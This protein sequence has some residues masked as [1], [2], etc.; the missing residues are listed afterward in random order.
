MNDNL[1]LWESVQETDPKHTRKANVGGNKITSIKPQYQVLKATEQ[2]GSYGDKWGFKNIELTYELLSI[3]L[4]LSLLLFFNISN[5]IET[6]LL[7]A[8]NEGNYQKVNTIL[9]VNQISAWEKIDGKPL[10]IHAVIAD[11]PN[12]VYLL[13]IRG[14]Q[15]YTNFCD[16]GFN[17]F[18]WAKKSDSYYAHAELIVIS[19]Q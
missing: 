15:M 8:I 2:W 14:A 6:E 1:K 3:N 12:I 5:D 16:E 7:N 18:D 4:I 11:Q 10:L 9:V 17:A 13:C 19:K